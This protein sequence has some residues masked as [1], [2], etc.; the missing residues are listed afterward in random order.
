MAGTWNTRRVFHEAPT[1][2]DAPVGTLVWT[3]V[4]LAFLALVLWVLLRLAG[5]R[6]PRRSR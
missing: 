2:V 6:L 3:V 5:F 4:S 1:Y